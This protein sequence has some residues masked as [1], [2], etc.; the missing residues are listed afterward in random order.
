M[1]KHVGLDIDLIAN[2]RPPSVNEVG[3][4]MNVPQLSHAL[5]SLLFNCHYLLFNVTKVATDLQS[6]SEII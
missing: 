2:T 6:S 1:V 3:W 4:M 5:A